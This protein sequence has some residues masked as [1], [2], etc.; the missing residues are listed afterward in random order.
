MPIN[1]RK[2]RHQATTKSYR[3]SLAEDDSIPE[4]EAVK[5]RTADTPQ[6]RMSTTSKMT[7]EWFDKLNHDDQ[8]DYLAAHPHSK[9]WNKVKQTHIDTKKAERKTREEDDQKK[10]DGKDKEPEPKEKEPAKEKDDAPADPPEKKKEV[11]DEDD[12]KSEKKDTEPEAKPKAEK[13]NVW[14]HRQNMNH[15]SPLEHLHTQKPEVIERGLQSMNESKHMEPNSDYRKKVAEKLRGHSDKIAEKVKKDMGEDHAHAET[16]LS[17]YLS[18]KPVTGRNKSAM[19]KAARIAFTTAL[20]VM[21]GGLFALAAM[22][23]GPK[24]IRGAFNL[25]KDPRMAKAVAKDGNPYKSLVNAMSVE[26]ERTGMQ[27]GDS[28]IKSLSKNVGKQGTKK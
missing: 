20:V 13:P 15:E 12:S 19:R 5:E 16:G 6:S 8:V 22:H 9:Y 21:P 2:S 11:K 3:S 27:M 1:E 10:K 28:D 18:G 4:P 26:L 24:I 25:I 7:A 17:E 14:R 23:F